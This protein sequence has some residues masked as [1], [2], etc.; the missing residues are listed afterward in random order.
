M[1]DHGVRAAFECGHANFS[2]GLD[3]VGDSD[4]TIVPE[5]VGWS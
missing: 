4:A 1:C 3:L 2:L 5:L